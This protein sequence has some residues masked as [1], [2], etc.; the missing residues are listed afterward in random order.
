MSSNKSIVSGGSAFKSRPLTLCTWTAR[1]RPG[2]G[3]DCMRWVW[4]CQQGSDDPLD[5]AVGIRNRHPQF[6][7]ASL[8]CARGSGSRHL[9]HKTALRG[10]PCSAGL[11][12]GSRQAVEWPPGRSVCR[13]EAR[14]SFPRRTYCICSERLRPYCSYSRRRRSPRPTDSRRRR[15]PRS[16]PDRR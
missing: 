9:G 7:T 2:T 13:S 6:A 11:W 1:V 8:H 5:T 10:I 15:Y 3:P 12:R 4:Q 14:C 16:D